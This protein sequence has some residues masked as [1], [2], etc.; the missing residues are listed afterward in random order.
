MI[1]IRINP[2]RT[3]FDAAHSIACA[4]AP[5]VWTIL[6]A[7][8]Q[9]F[10]W[11]THLYRY[12]FNLIKIKEYLT[13]ILRYLRELELHFLICRRL[14]SVRVICSIYLVNTKVSIVFILFIRTPSYTI[15][16]WS[17]L[18]TLSSYTTKLVNT[19]HP[20]PVRR[21]ATRF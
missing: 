7:N 5:R 1:I 3:A 12:R 16:I 14:E 10:F 20:K 8:P 2:P 21:I 6:F 19:E 4:F 17:E 13:L 11:I 15:S 18:R 9:P